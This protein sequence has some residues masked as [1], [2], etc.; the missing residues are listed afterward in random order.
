MIEVILTDIEGTT[1]S[2]SYV[3]DV[4]F[5]YSLER[6]EKFLVEN[7]ES[8][9]VKRIIQLLSQRLSK[10]VSQQEAIQTLKEWIKKDLKETALKELQGL[11]WEEGFKS[12]DLKG[13]VYP[14][15]YEMLK[16]WKERG[17]KIYVFSSGSVKA[18]RLFFS[19]SLYGDITYLFSGFFDTNIGSKKDSSSYLEIAKAINAP[20]KQYPLSF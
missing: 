1:S 18:Q 2:I 4:M 13:H 9:E 10:Q 5:P 20:Y 17:L 12:G 3:K 16:R 8:Q 15:A 14:D 6:L 19:H 11:I 7:W